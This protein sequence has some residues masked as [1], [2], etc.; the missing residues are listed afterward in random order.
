MRVPRAIEG[1]SGLFVVDATWGIIQPL[2]LSPGVETV[3]ELE[4]IAHIR[5]GGALV[6]CRLARYLDGGSI[7]TAVN[8]PHGE[9]VERSR[10]LDP[11]AL[12]VVFCNG[13]QCLA[14]SDAVSALLQAGWPAR[15]LA[16]YRGGLHDWVTL[17]LPLAVPSSAR[18][19]TG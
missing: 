1:D 16:Y 19:V 12:T 5:A 13:P 11:D 3:A 2:V 14:S 15:A 17:G 18:D 10:E 7:P 9:I 4:V 8:I 6:D